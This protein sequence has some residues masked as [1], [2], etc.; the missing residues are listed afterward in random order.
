MGLYFVLD[1]LGIVR[2]GGM[3]VNDVTV[4]VILMRRI[5]FAEGRRG[6]FGIRYGC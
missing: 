4:F 1:I 2:G 5:F 3:V 6:V